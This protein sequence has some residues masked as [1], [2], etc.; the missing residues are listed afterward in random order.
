MKYKSSLV[1]KGRSLSSKRKCET[2]VLDSNRKTI[3]L[4]RPP[5]QNFSTMSLERDDKIVRK[6]YEGSKKSRSQ[7]L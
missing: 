1:K 4:K 5:Q 7:T 3:M 6:L 2:P